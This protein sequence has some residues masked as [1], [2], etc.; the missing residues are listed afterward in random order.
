LFAPTDRAL[1][2]AVCIIADRAV[3][4]RTGRVHTIVTS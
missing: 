1:A 3:D 4:L 2:S